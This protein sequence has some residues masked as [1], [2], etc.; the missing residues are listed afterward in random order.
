M[1]KVNVWEIVNK[2]AESIIKAIEKGEI[3][4]Q[5]EYHE[6]LDK[7]Y[8]WKVYNSIVT[9][10]SVYIDSNNVEIPWGDET[11]ETAE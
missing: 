9:I 1:K 3:K 4:T 5:Q 10:V 11:T 6:Y 2:E 7:V 8:S